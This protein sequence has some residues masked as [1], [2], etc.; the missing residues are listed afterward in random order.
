MVGRCWGESM[1]NRVFGV[2][3]GGMG[4]SMC[5]FGDPCLASLQVAS[6]PDIF[7]WALAFQMV[8]L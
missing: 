1:A 3:Y 8:M 6:F 4:C 7:V 5:G 2:L